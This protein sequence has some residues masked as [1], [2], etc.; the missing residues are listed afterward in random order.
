MKQN[1]SSLTQIYR[2]TCR[3]QKESYLNQIAAFRLFFID[4]MIEMIT[5][6]IN[7]EG[8]HNHYQSWSKAN[9]AEI[10]R[11]IGVLLFTGMLQFSISVSFL[12]G[13]Q[14]MVGLCFR[15]SWAFATFRIITSL[16]RFYNKERRNHR[17]GNDKFAVVREL[18]TMSARQLPK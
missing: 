17:R 14:Q 13:A 6:H 10:R 7:E 12:S 3:M 2:P 5:K 16:I 4:G 18:R 9:A 11:F 15:N 1:I 8:F